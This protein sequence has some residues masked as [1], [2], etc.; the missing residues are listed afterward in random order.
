M[1]KILLV[2][3]LTLL[4]TFVSA[5]K[6]DFSKPQCSQDVTRHMM[7]KAYYL[8]EDGHTVYPELLHDQRSILKH[9]LELKDQAY[10]NKKQNLYK[11]M[12]PSVLVVCLIHQP[13]PNRPPKAC[14]ASGF[15]I[16]EDG[17]CVTNAHV[18][19]GLIDDRVNALA[20]VVMDY[21]GN[22]YPVTE[23][24]CTDIKADLCVFKIETDQ[25]LKSAPLKDD[26][27]I[28]QEINVIGHPKNRYYSMS[29]G[30][31]SRHY[32]TSHGIER[33]S[34]TAEFAQGSSG[35]PVIDNCGNV[36]GVVA[37]TSH[38]VSLDG[39]QQMVVN[40]CIPISSLI[41]M[42]E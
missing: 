25:L 37:S 36:V 24:L 39:H 18:F 17:I 11:A 2:T 1:N 13:D 42:I 6:I 20:N 19:D 9:P 3:V 35:G 22:V 27:I 10:I 29:K 23:I 14:N 38:L 5:Q 41:K 15:V 8:N 4:T 34:T 16:R 31:I 32:L 7:K 26:F 30:I 28:G 12:A 21:K 40:E 33:I